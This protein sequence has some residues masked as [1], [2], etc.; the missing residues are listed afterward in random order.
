MYCLLF[1][2]IA[3]DLCCNPLTLR[4]NAASNLSERDIGMHTDSDDELDEMQLESA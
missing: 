1:V 2:C 4:N 3:G